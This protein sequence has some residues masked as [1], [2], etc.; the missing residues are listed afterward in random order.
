MTSTSE[1]VPKITDASEVTA[2]EATAAPKRRFNWSSLGCTG[3]TTVFLATGLYS[4]F[5][6]GGWIYERQ[7]NDSPR[8]ERIATAAGKVI[9]SEVNIRCD[10]AG[11]NVV[12][13]TPVEDL[14]PS[15]I[16][17]SLSEEACAVLDDLGSERESILTRDAI[18]AVAEG[19][20]MEMAIAD[21][22]GGNN[23]VAS[24]LIAPIARGLGA[25]PEQ[26]ETI[27]TTYAA[28]F[29]SVLT[30]IEEEVWPLSLLPD[31]SDEQLIPPACV[32]G[33]EL[34]LGMGGT[35]PV[36]GNVRGNG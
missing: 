4:A 30:P 14:A 28:S 36:V 9:G 35:T 25:K 24:Q 20:A 13:T 3:M 18:G 32:P 33:G 17:V 23:C 16:I 6:A 26:A 11:K 34:D 31:S 21:T 22:E 19:A 7:S 27:Q 5:S 15:P 1:E 29:N 10:I 12:I 8:E 2:N